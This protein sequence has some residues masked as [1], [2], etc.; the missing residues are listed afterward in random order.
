[1][2]VGVWLFA[3]GACDLLRAA[4]DSI[5][6]R[7]RLLLALFGCAVL[8]AA[9]G[10]IGF[11]GVWW[12]TVGPVWAV[13]LVTWVVASSLALDPT[14]VHPGAWRAA[15]FTAL[16]VPL[17]ALTFVWGAAPAPPRVPDGWDAT[18]LGQV[19]PTRTVVFA[20]VLL[21]EL[22]TSNIVVRLLLDATGVSAATNEGALK[23]G[24]LLGPM[25]RVFILV[26]AVA[27]QLTAGAIVVA[28]KGLLRWPELQRSRAQGPTAVSEYF[29]IGSFASWLLGFLGWLLT[30]LH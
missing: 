16:A 13:S 10:L 27:G 17:V 9:G 12:V 21:F 4:R 22:S 29:L 2:I 19:G 18:L 23:G 24:R 3:L 11:T 7:R 1:V 5:S 14:S 25:E 20:G 8:T 30:M 28:A 6:A 15:A 26:L